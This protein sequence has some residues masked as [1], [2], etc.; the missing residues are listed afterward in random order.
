[1]H[2]R[3]RFSCLNLSRC[4]RL[5]GRAGGINAGVIRRLAACRS[6]FAQDSR[7]CLHGPCLRLFQQTRRRAAPRPELVPAG[8][9]HRPG[10]DELESRGNARI[11]R[12]T[13]I[14]PRVSQVAS[15]G[16][17]GRSASQAVVRFN[18]FERQVGDG[19]GNGYS[20]VVTLPEAGSGEAV[21]RRFDRRQACSATQSSQN[22]LG[23]KNS[24]FT[25]ELLSNF[26]GHD[27]SLSAA[28][29]LPAS[30]ETANPTRRYPTIFTVPGFSGTHFPISSRSA[31]AGPIAEGRRLSAR[32]ARPELSARPSTSLPTRPTTDR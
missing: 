8:T 25:R 29:L 1:M 26:Y 6:L 30:Y 20:D 21:A 11:R 14:D 23:E 7:R 12:A 10:R 3:L 28:V 19:P 24:S 2:T 13:T 16:R 9:I 17:P 15:R 31:A 27:V 18:P 4:H 5:Y 22:R 32:R